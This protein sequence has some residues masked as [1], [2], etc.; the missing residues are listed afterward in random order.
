MPSAGIA[1]DTG[2]WPDSLW[3]AVSS[4]GISESFNR[5]SRSAT[6]ASTLSAGLQKGY[7][8]C[9]GWHAR[10]VSVICGATG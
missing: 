5:L 4:A 1:P 2:A 8:S 7:V 9:G 3:R 10:V 6:R